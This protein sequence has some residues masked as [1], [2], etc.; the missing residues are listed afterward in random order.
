MYKCVLLAVAPMFTINSIGAEN[1]L[2]YLYQYYQTSGNPPVLG[3]RPVKIVEDRWKT[4]LCLSSCLVK[5]PVGKCWKIYIRSC[6]SFGRPVKLGFSI[7]L[8]VLRYG[9][10]PKVFLISVLYGYWCLAPCVTRSSTIMAMILW[11]KQACVF[12]EEGFQLPA[13]S[14]S[15]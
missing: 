15:W 12:H 10:G 11:D 9:K 8:P 5:I 7:W 1:I 13:P 6:K 14:Q 4:L 2:G 3:P